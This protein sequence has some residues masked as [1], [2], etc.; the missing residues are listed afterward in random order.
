MKRGKRTGDP[1]ANPA[2]RQNMVEFQQKRNRLHEPY[3]SQIYRN[4]NSTGENPSLVPSPTKYPIHQLKKTVHPPPQKK[5]SKNMAKTKTLDSIGIQEKGFT[6]RERNQNTFNR[7]REKERRECYGEE[8]TALIII[9][10]FFLLYM[11]NYYW[12]I[13]FFFIFFIFFWKIKIKAFFFPAL[14]IIR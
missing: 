11:Y 7:G 5:R 6:E 1:A 8:C 14:Y 4:P 3:S 10:F 2:I 13:V 9:I 12:Y